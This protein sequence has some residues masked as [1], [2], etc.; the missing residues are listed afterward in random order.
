MN[1]CLL[2]SK[3]IGSR[4]GPP[5]TYT[6]SGDIVDGAAAAIEGVTVTLTGDA[7]DSTT[8]DA[9][10]DYA[11]T[12]LVDGS[13]TVT[14]TKTG[15]TFAPTSDNVTISGASDTSDFVGTTIWSISGTITGTVVEGVTITLSGDADDS[16]TSAVDGTYS[17]T[18][19]VDGSYTVTPTMVGYAFTADHEDVAV[20]GGN[21]A[22][23]DMVSRL[24]YVR[25]FNSDTL[26][27]L[28][29]DAVEVATA[30]VTVVSDGVISWY[31]GNDEDWEPAGLT[32]CLQLD[33]NTIGAGAKYRG[34][35]FGLP[36]VLDTSENINLEILFTM[37]GDGYI[38][39]L[40][41]YLFDSAGDTLDQFDC[42]KFI[43]QQWV[44]VSREMN[45]RATANR[46]G[47]YSEIASGVNGISS[48]ILIG[49]YWYKLR[50]TLRPSGNSDAALVRASTG[51][52]DWSGS[53]DL[54]AIYGA[55]TG[56]DRISIAH[57]ITETGALSAQC[58]LGRIYI[59]LE[60]DG[61]P[62][63]T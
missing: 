57:Y 35:N 3:L 2:L 11:F 6:I 7:S 27:A 42:Q 55:L 45:T 17:F 38:G 33:S 53:G 24:Q 34:W 23:D 12:G 15:N 58:I 47:A 1:I 36:F 49:S 43:Q 62:S 13:Y 56:Q 19:L 18:G 46:F 41:S 25:T 63:D 52:A 37:N 31:N 59:G 10:G 5:P 51:A 29:A 50:A 32:R 4:K 28:P 21:V 40:E 14:P 54:S 44:T 8:T 39:V 60:A 30:G 48:A 9:S 61:W 22:V 16:T 20:S 26:G